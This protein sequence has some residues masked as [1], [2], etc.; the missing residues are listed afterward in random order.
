MRG[1]LDRFL[2]GYII[3]VVVPG[4]S[5]FLACL[6]CLFARYKFICPSWIKNIFLQI[7]LWYFRLSLSQSLLV[8][9]SG[10]V[11]Q[12]GVATALQ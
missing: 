7:K 1:A 8:G 12:E 10:N 9:G 3:I 5:F 4:R 6:I 2:F 11:S